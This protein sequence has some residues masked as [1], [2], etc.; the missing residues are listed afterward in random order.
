MAIMVVGITFI[1]HININSHVIIHT[2]HVLLCQYI[3]NLGHFNT[4]ASPM[5]RCESNS[6]IKKNINGIINGIILTS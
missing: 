1:S 5:C 4:I 3:H 2:D 6:F